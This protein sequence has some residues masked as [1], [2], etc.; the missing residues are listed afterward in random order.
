M[1][2]AERAALLP[3]AQRRALIGEL[4]R[5]EKLLLL[6]EWAGEARPGQL[7]PDG[8][9][10]IWMIM[11]GRGF[12]KTRAGSEWVLGLARA[13]GLRIELVGPNEDEARAVMVEGPAG[14]LACA[15]E[16]R[17]KWEPSNLRLIWPNGTM[18]FVH[19]GANPEGLRGPECDYAWCDEAAKWPRGQATWNNLMFVLRSGRLP[20]V[21]V[22]TTP[23]P[24]PL[25]RR[26]AARP[27]VVMTRGRTEEAALL[28]Q[29]VVDEL[30]LDFG[31]TRFGRQELD[32][33]L[34]DDVEGSLWPRDL[35]ERCRA[36]LPLPELRRVAVGV[37]P[38]ASAEGTCGIVV[39]ALAADGTG[40]VLA[41]ASVA[42]RRPEGW[43]RT[44]AAT[45]EAWGADRV[46]AEGN[47]GGAMVASV[48]KGADIGL[49]VRI[50]HA[51]AGKAAR[52]EPVAAL[53]EGGRAKF[54]GGFPELED[55]LAGLQAGGGYE[56]PGRSPD[57]ADAMVWAMTELMLG[58]RR[59]E[60]R[61]RPL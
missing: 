41:D 27:G 60:P 15:R 2:L 25:I 51:S 32:G 18:A 31:G 45:A 57:R 19:S 29:S 39:C 5:D 10:R 9:W 33:E 23:R 22:T 53:F 48:L 28:S 47:Q 42:G 12:G 1:S 59:A 52:A 4:S 54:A 34:I 58:K 3:R 43:A 49:P 17:P 24:T 20:R 11:A 37:D 55:E 38:P 36:S 7:A 40:L 44:V 14:I 50:V 13:P 26:L 6:S 35:I 16:V 8:D 46:V 21:L 56:G 30:F 61:I